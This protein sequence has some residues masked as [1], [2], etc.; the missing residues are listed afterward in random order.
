MYNFFYSIVYV[1]QGFDYDFI[2][3]PSYD[4]THT[5]WRRHEFERGTRP[6]RCVTR[7]GNFFR[8]PPLFALYQYIQLVVLVST[9]MMVSTVWSVSCLLLFYSRC[10]RAQPFVKVGA[11]SPCPIWSR[12]RCPYP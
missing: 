5:L 6:V 8:A 10:P 12:R 3:Y 2:M 1:F 7:A 9:F 4:L 11:R